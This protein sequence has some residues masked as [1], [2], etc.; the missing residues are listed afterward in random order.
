MVQRES[1]VEIITADFETYYSKEYSLTKLTTEAYVRD[2]Q[3]EVIMLG[4]RWP[5]GTKEVVTGTHAEIQYR[6][7]AINWGEYAVLCHNTLFDAAIFTWHFGVRPRLWLDTLSMARAMFGARNN[8]L[9]MLA[10]RYG[11]GE[12]GDEVV[13]AIGMRRLDF[14]PQEF[15]KYAQYCLNDVQLCYDMW[16]VMSEGWYNI[17]EFDRRETYP[18]EEL[19][20]IDLHIRMFSEPVLRLNRPKLEAHLEGVIRR[21]EELLSRTEF[22]KERLASNLQFA[23]VLG[24]LGVVPPTKTSKTTG[25]AT[26]AFAKT[27]PELKALLDHPDERV[28]AA[29]AAR[30]GTKS[31]LEETRTQTF[32]GITTRGGTLPVPLKYSYAR[33]KRS[34]G[35]DGINLQNLPARGG[36]E[37]KACIEAPPG[38][39]LIDCD[40]SNIEARVLAW[41]AGQNDLVQDFTNKVD[42]YCK[43]ATKIYGREITK[44]D[45]KE[46]FVGKT[47]TLGCFGPDTQVLTNS[48]WKSIV[49]VSLTDELWDGEAWVT[50][51]GLLNQGFRWTETPTDLGLTA[52]ADHEILTEHGWRA[53]SEVHSNRSLFQSALSRATLPSPSGRSS[54]DLMEKALDGIRGSGVRAAGKAL[55]TAVISSIRKLNGAATALVSS[56][57]K[58]VS[59]TG[60]T[61]ILSPMTHTG[62]AFS[63]EYLLA[64]TAARFQPVTNTKT[65]AVEVSVSTSLGAKTAERFYNTSS[66]WRGGTY[67]STNWIESITKK[68]TNLITCGLFRAEKMHETDVQSESSNKKSPVLKRRMQTYDIALA[69]PRNRFTVLTNQGPIIVHNCGYQTGALKLQATLRTASPPMNLSLDECQRI[70]DIYRMTYPRIKSLWYE[71]EQ[72]IEAMYAGKTRWFG[73]QGVVL[74]EGRKGVKLPSELYISYPQLHRYQDPNRYVMKWEYKDDT[75][76]VDIYGGKFTENVVQALARIIVMSQLVRISKKLRVALTV[77]DSIIALAREGERDEARAYVESCM[78]WVPQWA[79]GLPI[80]CE[81]KW[82][83]NYGE[84]RE[85]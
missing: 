13:N 47:V 7:D 81:S 49:Q 18:R 82:G 52:T 77:H 21:K 60:G 33:T 72:C 32:I 2:P 14:G 39:V 45:K 57:L 78:R 8:S 30:L 53:W 1:A 24:E 34:S 41:L 27:D 31:T 38:Y 64:S 51:S 63:T 12:K 50:H 70:V 28:Q 29:V 17:E 76:L 73:K 65:T 71:G 55:S 59:T 40:S 43:M 66:L 56:P 61:L 74:A 15:A 68:V 44:A 48:G 5:D 84:M 80:N 62:N 4:L 54:L 23:E 20:L 16:H 26:F 75:G 36:T 46:R 22:S 79:A 19:K 85:D 37:L 67:L 83:Y 9:A 69:G 35:G 25:K 42:V 58:P 3:F 6:L 11:I 10:K